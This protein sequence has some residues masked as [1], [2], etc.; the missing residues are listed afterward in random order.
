[1]LY[2]MWVQCSEWDEVA[3][4]QSLAH[5]VAAWRRR[6][7]TDVITRRTRTRVATMEGTTILIL[8]VAATAVEV[9][10]GPRH[11]PTVTPDTPTWLPSTYSSGM[12]VGV[13]VCPLAWSCMGWCCHV[14]PPHT[15]PRLCMGHVF[16]TSM[17]KES[18]VHVLHMVHIIASIC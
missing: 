3:I 8:D 11:Q 5:F 17:R 16:L 18:Y 15:T 14:L 13:P 2:T 9:A 7:I 1:V 12:G 6:T 10:T 4:S